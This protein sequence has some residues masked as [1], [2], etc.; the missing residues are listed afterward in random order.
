MVL[1]LPATLADHEE[2]GGQG[3]THLSDQAMEWMIWGFIPDR[4][5]EF[6]S[7]QKHPDHVWDPPSPIMCN[8]YCGSTPKKRQQGHDADCSPPTKAKVQNEWTCISTPS[9][10]AK[11]QL[12]LYFNWQ[13]YI[14]NPHC[15]W[16]TATNC[17]CLMAHLWC[18]LPALFRW[19]HNHYMIPYK[20]AVISHLLFTL[21]VCPA[22]AQND[23]RSHYVCAWRHQTHLQ[24]FQTSYINLIFNCCLLYIY[25]SSHNAPYF[26]YLP[27][28]EHT[29]MTANVLH[30]KHSNNGCHS[31]LL[32]KEWSN[33]PQ[34]LLCT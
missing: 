5:K 16:I 31:N 27:Q 20:S 22:F 12:C 18:S 29:A 10:H 11:T 6:F 2:H 34:T 15:T 14:N 1:L 8:G 32:N 24:L 7:Y 33:K 3:S 25:R 23:I 17:L 19:R 13:H 30:T 9:W 4:W 21:P 28:T 26:Y